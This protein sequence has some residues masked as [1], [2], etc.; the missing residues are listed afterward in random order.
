M[1]GEKFYK[2]FFYK[3]GLNAANIIVN[4][5]EFKKKIK[6]NLILIP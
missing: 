3:F 4:S 2:K 5:Q 1:V 6:N